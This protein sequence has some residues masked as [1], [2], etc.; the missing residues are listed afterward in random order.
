MAFVFYK[1]DKNGLFRLFVGFKRFLWIKYPRTTFERDRTLA[2]DDLGKRPQGFFYVTAKDIDEYTYY[3]ITDNKR[4][5]TGGCA[6]R[7]GEPIFGKLA[8]AEFYKSIHVA[9]NTLRSLRE[10]DHTKYMRVM[11]VCLSDVNTLN[12]KNFA[13][14]LTH[15][16]TKAERYLKHYADNDIEVAQ[17]I[18][19]AMRLTYDELLDTFNIAKER[20]KDWVLFPMADYGDGLKKAD[21]Y[22]V[23]VAV[24]LR[25]RK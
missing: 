4:F 7:K 21:N 20:G 5:F 12:R 1:T 19:E 23:D 8:K 14:A 25:K 24:K 15:K 22:P 18:E 13:I 17:D 2:F 6:T 16:E 3:V 9:F 11:K 10:S